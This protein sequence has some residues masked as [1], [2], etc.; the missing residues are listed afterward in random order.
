VRHPLYRWRSARRSR[1]LSKA[2]RSVTPSNICPLAVHSAADHAVRRREV[3]GAPS[4]SWA[5]GRLNSAPY[6]LIVLQSALQC[7]MDPSG[8]M[9]C[10]RPAGA[11]RG[12]HGPVGR[13]GI[14]RTLVPRPPGASPGPRTRLTPDGRPLRS[15]VCQSEFAGPP[16]QTLAR[17]ARPALDPKS[18][19]WQWIPLRASFY[20]AS[21]E[22]AR[23]HRKRL[24]A[25]PPRRIDVV[26]RA[27]KHER[28]PN[29]RP[30][31]EWCRPGP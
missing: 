26:I 14:R 11:P 30:T 4:G 6:D 5:S 12:P 18:H 19:S 22:M 23:R 24:E 1:Q 16:G 17:A 29:P 3:A 9:T 20:W 13:A 28:Q 8:R 2:P 31:V 15:A 10:S 27:D 21:A 25:G 7:R